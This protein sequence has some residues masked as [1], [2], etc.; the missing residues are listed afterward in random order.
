MARMGFKEIYEPSVVFRCSAL[1]HGRPRKACGADAHDKR[2]T[3]PKVRALGVHKHPPV[4]NY[5]Y[6][7]GSRCAI[8]LRGG[9]ES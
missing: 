3:I 4:V 1:R 5:K 6:D 2:R 9:Y 7:A 8:W